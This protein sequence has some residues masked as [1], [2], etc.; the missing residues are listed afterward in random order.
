MFAVH[1]F[2][3]FADNTKLF[4]SGSH[5]DALVRNI[6]DE[7]LN[8]SNWLKA[9]KLSLNIKKTHFII[10]HRKKPYV[11]N[12]R[13]QID[14]QDIEQVYKT[15]FWGVIID[16]ELSR[17]YHIAL[18]SGKLSRIGMIS[19]ARECLNRKSLLIL[20]H[21]FVYPYLTY[22]NQVWGSTYTS[23]L[24]KLF[25][26]QEKALKIMCS[27][28]KWDS[29]DPMIHEL[30]IFKF[31]DINL[32]LTNKFMFG[33][34]KSEFP[35]LFIS[36]FTRTSEVHNHFTRQH[37]YLHVPITKS[38]LGIF[39]ICYRGIVTWNAILKLGIDPDISE[40][41]F[42][43]IIKRCI[44]NQ[45]FKI[46][47]S[48][49]LLVPLCDKPESNNSTHCG[50]VTRY[51][52]SGG[53][54]LSGSTKPS[55]EPIVTSHEFGSVALFENNFIASAQTTILNNEFENNNF[56]IHCHISQGSMS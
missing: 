33:F 19:K 47:G 22:C 53:G 8:I 27:M 11:S 26:L 35:Q 38:N 13:I 28:P 7:W 39:A 10:F 44:M 18:A 49:E 51:I 30:G 48:S 16:C 37:N 34:Y 2:I 45:Q 3:L 12:L 6:N 9:N 41:V 43:K 4:D 50:L 29:T 46:R 17:K 42:S 23:N 40:A 55:P 56:K 1:P 32:Y 25:D 24:E 14:N 15:K 20:Y 5:V 31:H 52:G 21:S 36:F 54:L